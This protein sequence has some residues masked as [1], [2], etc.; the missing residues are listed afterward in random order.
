M[1]CYLPADLPEQVIVLRTLLG[2]LD[3]VVS[4][5]SPTERELAWGPVVDGW[6]PAALSSPAILGTVG[7]RAVLTRRMWALDPRLGW[8]LTEEGWVRLGWP[9]AR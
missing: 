1:A 4:G 5:V 6:A 3:R 9:G 8:A 7:D 2:R